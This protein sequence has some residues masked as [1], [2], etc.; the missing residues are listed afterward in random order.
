M[1]LLLQHRRQLI[2]DTSSIP[3]NKGFCEHYEYKCYEPGN[4]VVVKDSSGDGRQRRR[5]KGVLSYMES[6]LSEEQK[7]KMLRRPRDATR[8]YATTMLSLFN[9]WLMRVKMISLGPERAVMGH[10][11]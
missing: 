5:F 2:Y 1:K 3:L 9:N 4:A 10:I 7:T 11:F 6:K 8:N